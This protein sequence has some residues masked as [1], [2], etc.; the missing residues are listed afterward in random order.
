MKAG[1]QSQQ[2]DPNP[3]RYMQLLHEYMMGMHVGSVLS[4]TKF[5]SLSGKQCYVQLA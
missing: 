3:D 5:Q 2:S 4:E 1:E